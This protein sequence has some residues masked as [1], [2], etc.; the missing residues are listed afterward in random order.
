MSIV[1]FGFQFWVNNVQT[2]ASDFFNNTEVGRV[3]GMAQTG[4]GLGAIV[5]TMLIGWIVDHFSYS[6]VIVIGGILGPLAT[7]SILIF[8]GKIQKLR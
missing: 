3:T 6:P 5:F 2:L 7:L 8:C 1:L 4:A